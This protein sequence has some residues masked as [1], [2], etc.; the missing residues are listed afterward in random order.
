MSTTKPRI[1]VT[2]E[3]HTHEVLSRLSAVGGESMSALVS[4]FVQI[5]IPSL[6]RLV[7]VLERAAVAPKEATAGFAASV[8]RAERT[9]LPALMGAQKMGDLF[10]DDMARSL[11]PGKPTRQAKPG[12][13]AVSALR[14]SQDPRLV[15]RGS[16][17]PKQG[18][19]G[20][21]RG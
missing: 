17:T 12:A 14:G 4:Q 8:E 2:L 3:P 21:S 15:T 7:V 18:T 5:A 6:E 9:L 11:A 20:S 13:R 10:I 1:T 19:K 16:G